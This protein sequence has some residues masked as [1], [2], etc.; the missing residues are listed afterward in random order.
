MLT[1]LRR[2][3]SILRKTY[4]AQKISFPLIDH[5][6]G[7]LTKDVWKNAKFSDLF[8]DIRGEDDA[9]D[10]DRP[11]SKCHTRFKAVWDENHLYIGAILAS[12]FETQ[13]HFTERNSPIYQRDSDFEVFDD[14]FGSCHNYKEVSALNNV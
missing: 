1:F 11:D 13:A 10:A 5:L 4:V 12:D 3:L 8:D 9:P 2:F 6:D 7:D 14:P